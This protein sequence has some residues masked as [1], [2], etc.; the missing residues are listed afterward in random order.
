MLYDK[1]LFK[2]ITQYT[3]PPREKVI[4]D[5]SPVFSY[6]AKATQTIVDSGFYVHILTTPMILLKFGNYMVIKSNSDII[7][8]P[9]QR[10]KFAI[11]GYNM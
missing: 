2:E 9:K 4:I 1:A 3:M 11:F 5:N 10:T 8:R 6:I 7:T